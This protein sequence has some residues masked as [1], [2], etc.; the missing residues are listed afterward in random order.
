M[1]FY[2][3]LMSANHFGGR[4]LIKTHS[5]VLVTLSEHPLFEI[6]EHTKFCDGSSEKRAVQAFGLRGP[7]F[8]EA[9]CDWPACLWVVLAPWRFVGAVVAAFDFSAL[10]VSFMSGCCCC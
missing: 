4:S 7:S 9:I 6:R 3:G 1:L 8:C 5:P 2:R 10:L